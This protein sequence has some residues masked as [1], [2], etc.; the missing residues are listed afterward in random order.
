MA[1]YPSDL[2]YTKD[3]EWTRSKGDTIVVGITAFA[4]EQLGD[5]TLVD[6]PAVGTAVEKGK[7]FGVVESVKSVS[8][9]YA[10]CSGTVVAVNGDLASKPELVNDK[11]YE[12][13]WMVEIKVS[14]AADLADLLDAPSY[15]TH[16][17]AAAH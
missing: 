8:D 17:A 4:V 15:E 6:L 14:N 11:P 12:A 16:V 2:R 10:P 13:G 3:H 1:S 9:L 5:V 7:T